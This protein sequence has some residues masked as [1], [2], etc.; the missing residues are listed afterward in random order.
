[1][2]DDT[3]FIVNLG[4]IYRKLREWHELLPRVQPFYALKCNNDPGL[5]KLLA[6]LGLGFD[7]AS[8]AELVQI[9][10]LGVHP[11]RIL[12]ANPCKQISHLSYAATQG[13]DLMTFDDLHELIKVKN[14]FPTARLLLRIQS[15]KSHR[16]KHNFNK[17]FGCNLTVARMLLQQAK[18]MELNVVGVSFHV[19][20]LPQD[21]S[22]FSS[23]IFDAHTVFKMAHDLGIDMAILDI[24]GGFPGVDT[25]EMCFEN[26]ANEVNRALELYFPVTRGIHIIAEPGRYFVSS[27]FT[28]AVSVIAK[29]IVLEHVKESAESQTNLNVFEY[30]GN[31]E[32]SDDSTQ[33]NEPI[34]EETKLQR[35]YY[36]NDGVYGSFNNVFTDHAVVTPVVLMSHD[37]PQLCPS[38]LWGPTCDGLDCI[39]KECLLP[40]MDVGQWLYFNNMGAYTITLSCDFNGI[41]R[42]LRFYIC[43]DITWSAVY[44]T[45]SGFSCPETFFRWYEKICS[46]LSSCDIDE[47]E[48]HLRCKVQSSQSSMTRCC[49]PS[50]MSTC[51]N[52]VNN[53]YSRCHTHL[54][55]HSELCQHTAHTV[56]DIP[57]SIT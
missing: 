48:Q 50:S 43:D 28:L 24:G 57:P 22:S 41:S 30:T 13:V 16:A 10:H 38:V 29:R 39:M 4:E 36:V 21:V 7:C 42:P 47:F 49:I 44:P 45:Y 37:Q 55:C 5:V 51:G 34:S 27:S 9:R 18:L 3:F 53:G 1:G 33:H 26:V 14:H 23:T 52:F 8:K 20:S 56:S 12:Y 11:S 6:D 17:K 32:L 54:V 25:D 35:M 2:R 19:G 40:D 46:D 15:S 31:M